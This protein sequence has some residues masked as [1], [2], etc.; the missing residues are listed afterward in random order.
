MQDK[1]GS[2]YYSLNKGEKWIFINDVNLLKGTY[3]WDIPNIEDI[4]NNVMLKIDTDNSDYIYKDSLKIFTINP[5][6]FLTIENS[7]QD[8]VKTNMPFLI[9]VSSKNIKNSSYDLSYSL[10]KG[11]KWISIDKNIKGDTY[12]WDV[13]SLEGYKSILLR[14][15]LNT[16]KEINDLVNLKVMEQSINISILSPNGSESYN[17]GDKVNIVW[18]IKKIY[19]KTIDLYYSI[20]NG[21]N[22]KIIKLS[23][24]NSGKYNWNIDKNIISSN[25]CKIKVQSNISSNI[26]D[27]TDGE[28][29]I[30]GNEK[31]FNIITPNNGETIKRG[32]STFIYWETINKSVNKVDIY[33]SLD[34]GNNWYLIKEKLL[35]SG[36][37]NWLVPTSTLPSKNCFIKIVS[38]SNKMR[39]DLSD[40]PFSLK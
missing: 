6:P 19:D 18:S 14:A 12:L 23:A 37:Y 13:P 40:K 9:N 26:F 30:K 39:L 27:V 15:I 17:V 5:A 2:I 3:N 34:D 7:L 32:T 24:K 20:D 10:A 25:N 11:L 33:Y 4:S 28:F 38:S 36:Q 21:L 35:N 31:A 16:N 8:T 29:S 1:I 22:W